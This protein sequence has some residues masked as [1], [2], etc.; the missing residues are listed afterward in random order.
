MIVNTNLDGRQSGEVLAEGHSLLGI[1]DR[2]VQCGLGDTCKTLRFHSTT[3]LG[4][5]FKRQLRHVRVADSRTNKVFV[6]ETDICNGS[7][8]LWFVRRFWFP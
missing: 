4:Q 3:L 7:G 2:C 5:W 1:V 8:C 6:D